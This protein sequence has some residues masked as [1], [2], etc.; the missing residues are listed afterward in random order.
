MGASTCDEYEDYLRM[1]EVR[2]P[3]CAE[4]LPKIP[5]AHG[6][7][8]LRDATIATTTATTATLQDTGHGDNIYD[9]LEEVAAPSSPDLPYSDRPDPPLPRSLPSS[10]QSSGVPSPRPRTKGYGRSVSETTKRRPDS[11][12]SSESSL[13]EEDEAKVIQGHPRKT[14]SCNPQRTPIMKKKKLAVSTTLT[15]DLSSSE[16]TSSDGVLRVAMTTAGAK[17]RPKVTRRKVTASKITDRSVVEGAVKS[18]LVRRVGRQTEGGGSI[19]TGVPP[20]GMPSGL[21]PQAVPS[22]SSVPGHPGGRYDLQTPPASPALQAHHV[23]SQRSPLPTSVTRG[24]RSS[25]GSYKSNSSSKSAIRHPQRFAD[26]HVG[27]LTLS[28]SSDTSEEDTHGDNSASDRRAEILIQQQQVQYQRRLGHSDNSRDK[29]RTLVVVD[30][31]TETQGSGDQPPSRSSNRDATPVR[32]GSIPTPRGSPKPRHRVSTAPPSQ[33]SLRQEEASKPANRGS[34]SPPRTPSTPCSPKH[35]TPGSPKRT[36]P[37]TPTKARSPAQSPRL[38]NRGVLTIRSPEHSVKPGKPTT[39]QGTNNNHTTNMGGTSSSYSS[40]SRP[41]TPGSPRRALPDPP[42]SVT[43][44]MSYL[45]SPLQSPQFPR[46]ALTTRPKTTMST[47]KPSPMKASDV[48]QASS[49]SANIQKGPRSFQNAKGEPGS[50]PSSP[51]RSR[52]GTPTSSR[53]TTPERDRSD[54]ATATSQ[55]ASPKRGILKSKIAVNNENNKPKPAPAPPPRGLSKL[56]SAS[57]FVALTGSKNQ[58]HKQGKSTENSENTSSIPSAKG[59]VQPPVRSTR[60]TTEGSKGLAKGTQEKPS[61]LQKG[62]MSPR[63]PVR[64]LSV[65]TS[66]T[67]LTRASRSDLSLRTEESKPESSRKV[68]T[69]SGTSN[70]SRPSSTERKNSTGSV[71]NKSRA[72]VQKGKS[73][74]GK[75]SEP[76]SPTRSSQYSKPNQRQDVTSSRGDLRSSRSD[77]RSSRSDIRSSRSDV[78]Y[79][80]SDVRSSR[81]DLRSPKVQRKTSGEELKSPKLRLRAPSDFRSSQRDLRASKSELSSSKSNLSTRSENKTQ[82]KTAVGRLQ[83]N[84]NRNNS[85]VPRRPL[86]PTMPLSKVTANTKDSTEDDVD[87]KSTKQSVNNM[88]K[89]LPSRP[90]LKTISPEHTKESGPSKPTSCNNIDFQSKLRKPYGGYKTYKTRLAFQKTPSTSEESSV[91]SSPKEPAQPSSPVARDAYSTC[92]DSEEILVIECNPGSSKPI[93]K[94]HP[95]SAL[96][97]SDS[98]KKPITKLKPQ[99]SME[100][101]TSSDKDGETCSRQCSRSISGEMAAEMGESMSNSAF[102][103]GINSESSEESTQNFSM[104]DSKNGKRD[105]L[106]SSL[107]SETENSVMAKDESMHK[108]SA[109]LLNFKK[110]ISSNVLDESPEVPEDKTTEQECLM[111]RTDSEDTITASELDPEAGTES[112]LREKGDF[113]DVLRSAKFTDMEGGFDGLAVDTLEEVKKGRSLDSR[114]FMSNK[115]LGKKTTKTKLARTPEGKICLKDSLS[116][117]K[118]EEMLQMEE[119]INNLD[120]PEMEC[121]TS[122]S[123]ITPDIM[124]SDDNLDMDIAEVAPKV[125]SP[126]GHK[127]IEKEKV[128][129]AEASEGVSGRE[130]SERP[131]PH[132]QS[133]IKRRIKSNQAEEQTKSEADLKVSDRPRKEGEKKL[134]KRPTSFKGASSRR[135]SSSSSRKHSTSSSHSTSSNGTSPTMANEKPVFFVTSD[136]YEYFCDDMLE[137]IESRIIKDSSSDST[138]DDSISGAKD[139]HQEGSVLNPSLFSQSSGPSGFS[140]KHPTRSLSSPDLEC[141]TDPE[142]R[143]SQSLTSSFLENSLSLKRSLAT[144]DLLLH[145]PAATG[146]V[147]ECIII[148][149]TAVSD[150]SIHTCPMDDEVFPVEQLETKSQKCKRCQQEKEMEKHMGS[151]LCPR[152]ISNDD[153]VQA[154]EDPVNDKESGNIVESCQSDESHSTL[155]NS[156]NVGDDDIPV[157]SDSNLPVVVSLREKSSSEGKLHTETKENS[158]PKDKGVKAL[159]AKFET[160]PEND[161]PE[162]KNRVRS[163]LP[164]ILPKSS[165]AKMTRSKS[166]SS[167]DQP[168]VS[169][170]CQQES[171][172]IQEASGVTS[173]G[174]SSPGINRGVRLPAAESGEG[175]MVLLD[176]MSHHA[177][178]RDIP[179]SPRIDEGYGTLQSSAKVGSS[180]PS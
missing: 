159:S 150:S 121:F 88:M 180:F 86:K 72:S 38:G 22:G 24:P 96:E 68:P 176:T 145:Q 9:E 25:A 174:S 111:A 67:D 34:S 1:D 122:T 15:S 142:R 6:V 140:Q 35:S 57:S 97:K 7:A 12:D 27:A 158:L 129:A 78:R 157:C 104:D 79:S 60:H 133:P 135:R 179:K 69:R 73:V 59:L 98:E 171:A 178:Q 77:I 147:S 128:L 168:A 33:R 51:S 47:F 18:D 39:A 55:P 16:S 141:K 21:Q 41:T 66:R 163:K 90:T 156:E 13:E 11:S 130:K 153:L 84:T 43:P 29:D 124:L 155:D 177:F 36:L 169:P 113:L 143:F 94:Q 42:G 114:L 48:V 53:G 162:N 2:I 99:G 123:T 65:A 132:Y 120:D 118:S 108:R 62:S 138:E 160:K 64:G 61:K 31:N 136:D 4:Q 63:L 37:P 3:R 119:Y 74:E 89:T 167:E 109:V 91:P 19:H 44:P 116:K 76:P 139:F 149:E 45:R 50:V 17:A 54:R 115:I 173:K 154:T 103:S 85:P 14:M 151:E 87:K 75:L 83:S 80:R 26:G 146:D 175:P 46:K 82:E 58:G 8:H 56:S 93:I 102:D 127:M 134:A 107:S 101:D 81:S 144:S 71:S 10:P 117:T 49:S 30:I 131:I 112:K 166:S 32:R 100:T 23:T 40:Q 20:Q 106:Q 165:V 172:T 170:S 28:E 152:H 70:N 164:R 110:S 92:Y 161:Q 5:P 105:S 126:T 125:N 52:A 148:K 137:H 95:I